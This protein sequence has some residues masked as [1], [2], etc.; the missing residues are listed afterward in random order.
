MQTNGQLGVVASQGVKGLQR[1]RMNIGGCIGH[2]TGHAATA[3]E[4]HCFP[5]AARVKAVAELGVDVGR[6]VRLSVA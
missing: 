2:R 4:H 3:V 5:E 1:Q 6:L